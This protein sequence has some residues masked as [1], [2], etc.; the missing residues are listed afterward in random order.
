MLFNNKPFLFVPWEQ[1]TNWKVI[2]THN[3]NATFHLYEL[4]L[5]NM[6]FKVSIDRHRIQN[7]DRSIIDYAMPHLKNPMII[8]DE[9]LK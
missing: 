1:I 4:M 9:I 7:S 6:D 5:D 2:R 3:R 8:Q